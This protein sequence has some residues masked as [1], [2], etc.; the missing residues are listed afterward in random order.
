MS[1]SLKRIFI[2]IGGYGL[3]L[4]GVATGWLPGPG[5]IPLILGG[6]A[7]LSLHNAWARRLRNWL[8]R[9]GADFILYLF[10]K[11]PKIQLLYD[12]IAGIILVIIAWLV[13]NQASVWQIGLASALFLFVLMIVGMNR[14]R[15]IRIKRLY[16]KRPKLPLDD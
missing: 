12:F 7:L 8:L 5:G 1:Q 16:G 2:D 4:L 10:P 6:L 3:I 15:I 14:D 13:W 9:H 11:N